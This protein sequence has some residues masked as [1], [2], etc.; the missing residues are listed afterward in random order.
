MKENGTEIHLHTV[1]GH[2]GADWVT[3]CTTWTAPPSL[4]L[5]PCIHSYVISPWLY[6]PIVDCNVFL[7]IFLQYKLIKKG[8]S[9]YMATKTEKKKLTM[10]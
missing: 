9:N 10:A 7:F 2:L 3:Q 1:A 4:C 6:N 8:Y 5:C